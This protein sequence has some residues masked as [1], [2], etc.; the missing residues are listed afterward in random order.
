[1]DT[2]DGNVVTWPDGEW[3]SGEGKAVALSS[4]VKW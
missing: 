4:L 3:E 2:A 1:M